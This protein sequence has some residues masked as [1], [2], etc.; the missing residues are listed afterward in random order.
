MKIIK[1]KKEELGG[2]EKMEREGFELDYIK[3]DYSAVFKNAMRNWETPAKKDTNIESIEKY[4]N[5]IKNKLII[6]DKVSAIW[7]EKLPQL[8]EYSLYCKAGR[9]A[10]IGQTINPYKG[11]LVF[12]ERDLFNKPDTRL[13]WYKTEAPI[14]TYP[15]IILREINGRPLKIREKF[16]NLKNRELW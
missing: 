2:D 15:F 3:E 5:I 12:T 11:S 6:L 8:N 4:E 1:K 13:D 9:F 10:T 7:I 14:G 16:D